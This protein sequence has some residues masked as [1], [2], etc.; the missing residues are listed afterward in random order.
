MYDLFISYR[1]EGGYELARLLYSSFKEAGLNP[2]FD[3]EELRS[4]PFDEKLYT[5]IEESQN[6]VLVLSPNSLQRCESEKDWVRLEIERAI[7]LGKNIIPVMMKNFTFP[8]NLPESLSPLPMFNGATINQEYFNA[9]IEKIISLLV[10]VKP[11]KAVKLDEKKQEHIE[12]LYHEGMGYLENHSYAQAVA[13]FEEIRDINPS[14]VR[15]YWGQLLAMYRCSSNIELIENTAEDFNDSQLLA[16]ALALAGERDYKIY[17]EV[18]EKRTKNCLSLAKNALK[19]KKYYDCIRFSNLVLQRKQTD[20]SVIWMKLLAENSVCTSNELKTVSVNNGVKYT[21]SKTYQ[22]ILKY[23]TDE[24]KEGLENFQKAILMEIDKKN[25]ENAYNQ[26]S[27]S[28]SQNIDKAVNQEKAIKVNLLKNYKEQKSLL[29]VLNTRKEKFLGNNLFVLL[30]SV[31][32]FAFPIFLIAL[33]LITLGL[34]SPSILTFIRI[35]LGVVAVFLLVK[36][37]KFISSNKKADDKEF[38]YD[39]I[40]QEIYANKKQLKEVE[41]K[42]KQLQALY[43]DFLKHKDITMEEMQKYQEIVKK[44]LA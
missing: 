18:V 4:G 43:D 13:C 24:E 40:N 33:A 17:T 36:L 35:G 34:D 25:H 12:K 39:K 31:C 41:E 1:R 38:S 37:K 5:Y 10:N 30:F 7:K 29:V 3:V 14:Y 42:R 2:F 8:E 19:A 28:I 22:E 20:L 44:K 21:K 27:D 26:C 15:S 32:C 11:R 23:A 6:F 9:S 16:S